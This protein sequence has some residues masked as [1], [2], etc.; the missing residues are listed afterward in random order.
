MKKTLIIIFAM[1]LLFLPLAGFAQGGTDVSGEPV[2]IGNPLDPQYGTSDAETG[3]SAEEDAVSWIQSRLARLL[4]VM[5][6]LIGVIAIFPAVIG[7]FRLV[8]SQGASDKVT[9]AKKTITWGVLGVVLGL[10]GIVIINFLLRLLSPN[11]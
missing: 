4:Q 5:F 10:G 2:S 7:G 3:I 8:T 11:A 6:G 9:K 1:G